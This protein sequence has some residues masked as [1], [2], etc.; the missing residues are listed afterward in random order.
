MKKDKP[1]SEPLSGSLKKNLFTLCIAAL[2]ILFGI[3]NAQAT[4]TYPPKS[5]A[6]DPEAQQARISGTVTDAATGEALVGVN[7]SVEGT[8]VGTISDSKGGFSLP[9][10]ALNAVL[11]ISYVG[12]NTERVV[13]TGQQK[14]E[15]KITANV[16]A[17]NEVVVTSLGIKREARSLGYAAASVDNQQIAVSRVTN[18]GNSLVGKVAGMVVTAPT[19][20]PGGSSKIRI[21][22]QSSFGGYNS[23]LIIVN[24][25]PFSN[26][27]IG[28][29]STSYANPNG[30]SSDAGDGLQS[31]NADDIET[32]TVLK[33]TAAAALY[34]FRAKDGAIIITTKSGKGQKGIGIEFNSNIQSANALDY[35]DWQYEYGQG[36]NGVRPTSVADAQSSGV[37]SF[38]EKFDGAPTPQF[39]GS[40]QPYSPHN[41]RIKDYYVN[42]M[43]YTNSIALSAGYDKGNFRLSFANTDA[44]N[45]VP[46]SDFHKKIINAN[47][48]YNFTNKLS[49]NLNANYSNEFNHNPPQIGIESLCIPTT[50][51][52][53]ANSID[54]NWLKNYKTEQGTEMPLARF[55]N[56]DNP[57]WT[58]YEHTEDIHRDRL[59]GN[60]SLRYQFTDWLY[61]MGRIGQDYYSRPTN[62]NVPTGTR[63]LNAAPTGFNGNFY[64][65]VSTFRELNMD[66][67][68]GAKH[69]FGNLG[70]DLTVGG[71]RMDQVTD[72]MGTSVVNFYVRDLYTIE[73]GQTKSPGYSYGEKKV[74]S[75]Y[76][77][78]ELSYKTWLFVNLTARN[79]WFSTLNP[80]SNNYLYPSASTSFVFSDVFTNRPEWFSFGKIRVAYAE[81]G[82]DTD[83]YTNALYYGLNANTLNG[84]GMG[85]IPSS[86]SPNPD[87]KPLKV[88]ESEVGLELRTFNS[89]VNLDISVYKK[90]TVDEILDVAISSASG[91]NQ[92]KVN[93]GKL[94]NN[95]IEMMLTLIPVEG[96]LTWE[97]AFS[98]A[99]NNSKVVELAGGQTS[100]RVATGAWVGFIAHELGEPLASV[101]G[102]DYKRDDQG[103]ILTSAGKPLLGNLM[104]YGSGVPTWSAAWTNSFTYKGFH[105]FI[106]LDGKGG[107]VVYSNTAFN[108]LRHGLSKESLPGREGGVTMEG[109][110]ADGTPNTT[111][112]PA[113]A[114][115]S[116]VRGIGEPFIYKGDYFKLRTIS[117]GYD[118]K[119]IIKTDLIRGITVSVF[120][121]NVALLK[122]YLANV[123]PE[124]TFATNDN[125]QGME[126]NTLPTTRSL[127]INLNVKF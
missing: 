28:A 115:Y 81:V 105:L 114:F 54:V 121:N 116:S 106:Q 72:R 112:V 75:L 107:N 29:T 7:I 84:I 38:G 77:T 13:Y 2:L 89:R 111:S 34:G 50:I 1:F 47:F 56:R 78:L 85:N 122:K 103:R 15:I 37:W 24:G 62:Y 22:G 3:L 70:M 99:I 10:P 39:D 45:I 123:D 74:N 11:V 124:A 61:A 125:Y 21:R 79:D 67:L 51:S 55:T 109:W 95:G 80:K 66:F 18:V 127:G 120:C 92:T 58:A 100:F 87:L 86:I 42:G 41:N 96:N 108:A 104:T 9:A 53:F 30:G 65:D 59:F 27:S 90:N 44:N 82:G 31:L 88:K 113:Q 93:I 23:P 76:G 64:Q 94:R 33:G 73:N 126:V 17:L 57:Y 49:V 83:P 63:W 119:G 101:Q 12:Y 69:S 32:M 14:I 16:L 110:N 98:G 5:M 26:N 91:Y 35:T 36:E 40:T 118:L 25:V 117:L 4:E 43:T 46:N 60:I 97:T 19:S 6:D 52:T 20:G 48:D 71:N 68:V 102:F 8:S